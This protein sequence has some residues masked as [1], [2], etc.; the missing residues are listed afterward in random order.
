MGGGIKLGLRARALHFLQTSAWTGPNGAEVAAYVVYYDDGTTQRIPVRVG[1]EIA[2][3]YADPAP[4]PYA[5]VAWRGTATDKPGPIGVLD[6]RWANPYPDKT[7][8]TLDF[9]SAAG[10]TVPVLIAVTAEK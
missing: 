9:V 5:E 10:Q 3:W 2:D 7:I 6:L 8:A 4:L 1:V